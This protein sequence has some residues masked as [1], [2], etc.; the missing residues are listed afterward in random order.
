MER[1]IATF[2]SNKSIGDSDDN[3]VGEIII[4]GNSIEFYVRNHINPFTRI[5]T[6]SDGVHSYSIY[7]N[8]SEYIGSNKTLD[9]AS[10]YRVLCV[11]KSS[12]IYTEPIDVENVTNV[13]FTIPELSIWFNKKTVTYKQIPQKEA[14]AIEEAIDDVILLTNDKL[15]IKLSFVSKS[16][17]NVIHARSST[18][19]TIEKIPTVCISYHAP[20][21]LGRVR[22]DIK[23]NMEFW[24]LIIGHVSIAE[25]I[26]VH[27]SYSNGIDA[28]DCKQMYINADYS[29]NMHAVDLFKKINT[30]FEMLKDSIGSIYEG[31]I[32][33]YHDQKYNFL[34]N[35]YFTANRMNL[36]SL[37]DVFVDY[38]R[39]LE[40][41]EIRVSGDDGKK[42]AIEDKIKGI[43]NEIKIAIKEDEIKEKI[44]NVMTS[45]IPDWNLNS[46]HA[47]EMARWISNG[48][49]GKI[50]L[51]TRLKR[52]DDDHLN[53]IKK[54]KSIIK[55][56][57][58]EEMPDDEY[59]KRIVRTR[60]FYSHFKEDDT[61]ILTST[62]L[63]E[64]INVLKALILLIFYENMGLS[65]D[66]ARKILIN[67]SELGFETFCLLTE[68][69]K[70]RTRAE[71]AVDAQVIT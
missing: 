31:W 38:V 35:N 32:G 18:S 43:E 30:N 64:T 59:Y 58:Q 24:G 36:P 23:M 61:G 67:D 10:C 37:E 39:F 71:N 57:N 49:I 26:L 55:W 60:N 42:R 66:K 7:V 56:D 1:V 13:S 45:V 16:F 34:I 54:N 50:S 15:D 46:S 28:K 3:H 27:F 33:F 4:D 20:V 17:D 53:V 22:S 48:Y 29:Y 25:D 62:E 14:I 69:E 8:G 5:Y 70:G 12:R 9:Y 52:L 11:L 41:Y 65:I 44:E 40:G 2:K 21:S 68:E 19:V 51:E 47:G 6:G 63:A